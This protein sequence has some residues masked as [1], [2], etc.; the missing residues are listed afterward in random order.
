MTLLGIIASSMKGTPTSPVAGYKLWL[1]AAD[2]STITSSGGAV[3][4]WNDKSAFARNFTQGTGAN[5]PT[6]N[7]RTLNGKN[8]L[9]YDGT[10]DVMSCPSSTSFFNYLHSTSGTTF[11]VGIRDTG[12][13]IMFKNNTG[14]SASVGVY[15]DMQDFISVTKG[16]SGN[17]SAILQ[18][19]ITI[20]TS[21]FLVSVKW[22]PV[23][24]T[25]A[26][27]VNISLNNGAFVGDVGFYAAPS[28]ADATENMQIGNGNY[29]GAIG[30][31]IVYEGLL[32]NDDI[33][34]VKSYLLSKWG[35]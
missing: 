21:G 4:Q 31:F 2:A 1:D 16:V 12:N 33:A 13:G 28:T 27:R 3:S 32:S 18:N 23:S 29:N 20:P 24:T 34:S 14:G 8:V 7:S 35:L 19:Q 6:T 9:D 25:D 30:E 26:L 22:N 10:N 11:F 5:Q 17:P 15:S